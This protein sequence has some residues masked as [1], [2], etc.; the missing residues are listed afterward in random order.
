[1]SIHSR[2][3]RPSLYSSTNLK[4]KVTT[5]P[6]AEPITLTELKASLR[7]TSA[8]EDTLLTQ[9][10]T[11]AREMVERFTGRKLINQTLT[12]YATP[13]VKDCGQDR[14]VYDFHQHLDA[15]HIE[16]DWGPVSS[17]TSVATIDVSNVET[18]YASTNYYL[19]NFDQ[20][21]MPRIVFNSGSSIPTSLRARDAWKIVFVAGYGAAGASV[22]ADIRRACIMLAGYLWAN[23]GA[24][25]GDCMQNCGA[26]RILQHYRLTCV[27]S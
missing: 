19:D 27:L 9:Y 15:S 26:S 14:L 4:S 21:L 20:N 24:C 3:E 23:R 25:D 22:P 10:I 16:F 11:D 1:M 7:I 18:A 5:A 17:V 12:A 6:T 13:W 2:K 8:A